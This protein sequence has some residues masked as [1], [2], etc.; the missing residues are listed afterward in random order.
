M[1]APFAINLPLPP[2]VNTLFRNVPGKGRVRTAAYRRWKEA[3]TSYAWKQ[4][5]IG[6]FPR[7]DRDFE[8]IVCVPAK[9]QG[10]VDNRGKAAVDILVAWA[11][12][13]DDS[14]AVRVA[15]QRVV[16]MPAGECRVIVRHAV[17]Q[18]LEAA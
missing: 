13:S 6:G 12:I 3:C 17:V 7:F 18:P 2:S 1:T 4:K 14:H 10:D 11:I 8:V 15:V 5:P 9:M 16:D